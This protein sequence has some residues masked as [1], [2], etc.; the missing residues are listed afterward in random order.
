MLCPNRAIIG[1][2]IHVYNLIIFRVEPCWEMYI[3][4][5]KEKKRN[6]V[7]KKEM[8]TGP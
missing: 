4:L 6:R 1:E 2:V 8:S 7:E 3:T 5:K